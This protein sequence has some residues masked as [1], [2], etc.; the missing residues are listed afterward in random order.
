MAPITSVAA[1]RISAARAVESMTVSAEAPSD[2]GD[3][4]GQL[5]RPHLEM[6][7]RLAVG[8]T[9]SSTN[10]EDAVQDALLLSWRR[11]GQLR[12]PGSFRPWFLRIVLNCCRQQRR[13]RW[14]THLLRADLGD[15]AGA[16]TDMVA[17]QVST[18]SGAGRAV[19]T[20]E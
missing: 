7:L 1:P 10:A 9:G 6:A 14:F 18:A 5:V 20:A 8:V 15:V 2:Q 3:S 4:F 17:G 12:D 13:G 16:A 19:S 11:I